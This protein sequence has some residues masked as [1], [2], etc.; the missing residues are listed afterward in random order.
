VAKGEGFTEVVLLP[1]CNRILDIK[2]Q[3]GLTSRGSCMREWLRYEVALV[4][5]AS[6]PG[7]Y[8]ITTMD[9]APHRGRVL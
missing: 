2:G 6:M 4:L 9:D 7:R 8:V 1:K 3:G 5:I